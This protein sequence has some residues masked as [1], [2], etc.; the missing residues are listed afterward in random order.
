[1]MKSRV[2]LASGAVLALLLGGCGGGGNSA[3]VP[4]VAPPVQ[5]N[6]KS[7]IVKFTVVV[8][9]KSSAKKPAYIS[10]A[11]QSLTVSLLPSGSVYALTASFGLTPSSTGCT[12]TV[13][14]TQ[15]VLQLTAPAGAY[16]A[17]ISTFDGPVVNGS[18]TGNEL[19]T[20]QAIAVT[21]VANQ[22]ATV[23]LTL[24]GIP[25]QI[26]PTY[27]GSGKFLVAAVDADGN[28]IIGA[29]SPT[30]T[31]AQ[32]GGV[33]AVTITQPTTASPEAFSIAGSALG[34]ETLTITAAYPAGETNACAQTG[35]VCTTS[36]SVSYAQVLWVLNYD[37]S[38]VLGFTVPL[39]SSSQSAAYNYAAY[40]PY[41]ALAIDK[42]GDMFFGDYY[43]TVGPVAEVTAPYT[44]APATLFSA[45]PYS[46]TV[47]PNGD[48]FEADY[49]SGNI[50]AYA[51]PYTGTPTATIAG[52]AN[53]APYFMTTDSNNDLFVSNYSNGTVTEYAPPY[54]SVTATIT[55][56]SDPT[57][58][59]FD[60]SGN[61]W[62]QNYSSS[63]VMEF[64]PPFSNASTP[65]ATISTGIKDPWGPGTFDANGNLYVPN[66]EGGAGSLGS[67][68]EYSP[69]FS[70]SSAPV[71]TINTSDYPYGGCFID[72]AGNLYA[73]N[74][75][76][77]AD[78]E[79]SIQEFTPPFSS[80]STAAVTVSTGLSYP[81][82]GGLS[83]V[84]NLVVTL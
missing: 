8:P 35:A 39:S 64:K 72:G 10:P 20:A 83:P 81:Y 43:D 1:M 77:G 68:T 40:Y 51:S 58:I 3:T 46:L 22:T 37:D 44:A 38:N 32:S 36:F 48:L 15:C 66:Y 12:S 80:S 74:Y 25:A 54:T 4:A 65:V 26:Q 18:A 23:P 84:K 47:A 79:G 62:V 56:G 57:A 9:A 6:A 70:N 19:S 71:A 82:L 16:T 28:Y 61:L 69:P 24:S 5:P 21:V 76:G 49:T 14:S 55:V 42:T 31:V 67:I 29:G 41:T 7:G 17:A 60:P 73:V 63:N 50:L 75:E 53:E 2:A 11:T 13:A 27:L 52:G 33:A 30:F 45:A 78:D 34:A 59:Y